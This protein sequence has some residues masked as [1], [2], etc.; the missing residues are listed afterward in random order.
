[1][2]TKVAA[3]RRIAADEIKIRAEYD[4]V[5]RAACNDEDAISAADTESSAG[6]AAVDGK[7]CGSGEVI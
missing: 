7:D 6:A 1:M 5:G 2:N 4:G 3:I